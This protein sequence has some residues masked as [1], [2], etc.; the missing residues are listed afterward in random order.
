MGGRNFIFSGLIIKIQII[1]MI[2]NRFIPLAFLSLLSI[3]TAIFAQTVR[4]NAGAGRVAAFRQHEALRGSSPYQKMQWR[5]V[6]PD[7]ISGRVTE[8]AGI[9]G[10]KN[11]IYASFAT[12]GFWKTTD[13]GEN[14]IP[15]TDKLGT[16]SI[17][18]FALAP[19]NPDI[20]YLGTGEANIFRASLPGMGAYKST[21]GGK[22]WTSIGLINTG[23]IARILVHPKDPNTVYVAAGGNEWSYNNDRGVFKTTDGGK[24]WSK[25]LGSDEKT[26]AVDM[27]MDPTNPDLV[28]VSTWNRIR[29]R[30]SDPI[31]ED[32]DHLY[33]TTDGGKSWRK[34]TAG[35][36]ETKYTGRV[37]LAFSKSNP[38]VVYAYVDNHTSKRD[39]KPGELDPYGR[40]IQVIPFGVQV[41]RSE[42][43]GDTWKKV[44]TEDDKLERFAGT[45]GWVFGQIRVDPNDENVVYIMGVPLAKSTDGGKTFN[46]MRATDKDSDGQHGDNH[47]LWIDPT[48]SQYII[49]GNDGGVVLSYNGGAKWKN[50]FRKIPTTQFYN[51]TYDMKQP[52]NIVGSVQDEGSFMG[53]IKNTFG[54]KPEGI[55]AW[56]DA[57]GGEGTIIAMD[58]K[59]PD[60][61]YASTF[62]GRLTK[63]DLRMPKTE[64]G[65]KPHPDSVRTRDIYPKKADDEEVHRGEWLAYTMISPHDNKTLY[66]GFQY[67]FESND[68]GNTWKRISDDLTYND[69]TRMGRTPYAINHQAI[70][71]ID[72]SPLKKGLLYAGTDD[73]RVWRR[74]AD[75]KF[76]SIMNGIPQNA[77]VSRLVASAFKEG[78]VYLTLSNRREDDDKP[79][80]YVS[81]DKGTTWRSIAANLP[82][83]PVNVV[84]E[85]N[86]NPNILYCGTDMGI[87]V[88]TDRGASWKSL[89]ANL[90]STVSVNDLFIHPRDRN[91]VIATYGRGVYVMDDIS[92]IK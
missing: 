28:I 82:A 91:L 43:K 50:F 72:E 73:G 34:L 64:W 83:S 79:Y 59:D 31:P 69:K 47:A 11:I 81:E 25:I 24:T 63:S 92:S 77:H 32:G 61:M 1:T 85:D 90:P 21:D 57:P 13:A 22:N 86:K 70:T 8:V 84:R 44:S 76:E 65:K 27:V 80:I 10:N 23:T 29:R 16:L 9:P 75:G 19:S 66:H 71:A 46:A 68:G 4:N 52:Y 39:P 6:G 36:P 74:A 60:I 42:D 49:N 55:M 54:K 38:N 37:G 17:G 26:G 56:D 87:Y 41:Y 7:L 18:A 20:I 3:S 89:Q 40:P 51:I 88:S 5:N 35:L 14:W 62:Y 15:L 58:P 53:S 2:K 12:G 30:W 33:K 45:Y 78:R 48:N 67:L